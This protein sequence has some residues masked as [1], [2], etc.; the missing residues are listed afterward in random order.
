MLATNANYR[1]QNNGMAKWPV[2][3]AKLFFNGGK[4]GTPGTNDIYFAT[5]DV[6]NIAN[7]PYPT[8]W[9][10]VLKSDSIGSMSQQVDPI[11]GVSTIGNIT[12]TVTD[13]EG[14]VSAII[15]AANNAGHGLRRQRLSIYK[16]FQGMDWADRVL[17]R[18]MQIQDLKLSALNEYTITAADVQK[19]LQKTIF[20]PMST[21]TTGTI[22]ASGAVTISVVDARN[23]LLATSINYGSSGFILIDNEIMRWTSPATNSFTVAAVDRGLFGTT[24]AAHAVNATVTEV[25]YLNENPITMALKLMESSGVALA[26]GTYDAYPAHWGCGMDNSN[27]VAE[28]DWLLIGQLLTGLSATTPLPANGLQFEFV[29]NKG[30]VAKTFIEGSILKILGAFGFVRGDG[31]YSIRAYNDISNA[32]KEN[33]AVQLTRDN[34]TVWG[35]LTYNYP[36]L[37]NQLWIN[38]DEEPKLS[39]KYIRSTLFIDAASVKKW[40]DAPQLTYNAQGVPPTSV[41]INQLYQRFQR[42]LARYS[43][44]PMQIQLTLMPKL[45]TLEIGDM[46]RVTLPIR[47]LVTGASLDRAFEVLSTQ[48]TPSTGEIVIQCIAQPEKANFWF[49][50]VGNVASIAISPI[51]SSI[52][53]GGTQQLVARGFD[54]NGIQVPISSVSWVYSGNVTVNSSGLVTAGSVGTGTVSAVVGGIQ[55]NTATINVTASAFSG[56]V[57]SVTLMPTAVNMAATQ[58]QQAAAIAYDISSNQINNK[59]FNWASSNTGVATVTAGPSAS[60]IITGVANGSAN[61]TATETGS[62]VVSPACAVTIATPVT[63]TYTP[64]AL[65][66]SAYQIGTQITSMGGVGGPHTIPNGYNFASGDYWF[67]GNVTLPLG[68]TCTINGTVRI[69]SLGNITINGLIDGAGRGYANAGES[70]FYSS[71]VGSYGYQSNNG[72]LSGFVGAGGSGG[73][74]TLNYNYLAVYSNYPTLNTAVL[75]Q[76]FTAPTPVGA[77]PLYQTAPILSIVGTASSGGSWTAVAGLPTNLAGSQ[78]SCGVNASFQ[79]TY[80]GPASA[81]QGGNSGAGLLLMGRGIFVTTGQINLNGTNGANGVAPAI[82]NSQNPVFGFNTGGGGGGGGSF[83]ALAERDLNGLPVMSILNSR[84]NVSGGLGGSEVV[85]LTVPDPVAIGQFGSPPIVSRYTNMAQVNTTPATAGGSGAIIQQV[86]G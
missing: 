23:F 61:I 76:T 29:I 14:S 51:T 85:N 82:T 37:A 52:P 15:A 31:K 57:S 21:V 43:R 16:M 78:A 25:I 22:A 70:V 38:Y 26:N 11:N 45:N 81:A 60:A 69:F 48:L 79:Y 12:L 18:T 39:G 59:V 36:A 62:S 66:N 10:P 86:I 83:V 63:P 7:F 33:C 2:Y 19:R 47:D 3:V 32:I 67:D 17:V 55:S 40:G 80:L 44:P 1:T 56:T 4:D 8:H 24:A 41:F 75:S 74:D 53:T 54:A 28:S 35:D 84:I 77:A 68:N 5:C 13:Y 58:T 30:I 6:N 34:V 72:S 42:V 46:V 73:T 27:D 71:Y 9:F 65:A 64:P 20:N 49:Q 50:G